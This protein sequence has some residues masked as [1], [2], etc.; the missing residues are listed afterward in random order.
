MCQEVGH[1]LGLDHQDENFGNTPLGTCM[2]YSNDPAP[3]QHPNQHD[4]NQLVSI[5][6]HLDSTSTTS[7]RTPRG[8]SER[9]LDV[10]SEWGQLMKSSRGGRTQVFER[11]FG[12]GRKVVTFVI[13][14]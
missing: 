8:A 2:D 5:Y 4:Y 1:I 11:D 10:P 14:A 13:W 6:S 12:N 3:N 9:E 7:A